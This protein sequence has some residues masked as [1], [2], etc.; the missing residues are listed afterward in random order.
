MSS[1]R[2]LSFLFYFL[3]HFPFKSYLSIK[4][5]LKLPYLCNYRIIDLQN[6]KTLNVALNYLWFHTI[7]WECQIRDMSIVINDSQIQSMYFAVWKHFLKAKSLDLEILIFTFIYCRR[8]QKSWK[9]ILNI[10]LECFFINRI[11]QS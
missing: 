7:G 9:S 11:L 2:I 10:W 3:M 8:P 4:K 1:S 6:C 5:L